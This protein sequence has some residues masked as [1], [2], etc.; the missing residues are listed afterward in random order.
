[1]AHMELK[2]FHSR[3]ASGQSKAVESGSVHSSVTHLIRFTHPSA[4]SFTFLMRSAISLYPRR[5]SAQPE[6]DTFAFGRQRNGS[7]VSS[8]DHQP[9]SSSVPLWILDKVLPGTVSVWKRG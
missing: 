2:K 9:S 5:C 8:V 1:M 3:P 6:Y 4:C 7:L